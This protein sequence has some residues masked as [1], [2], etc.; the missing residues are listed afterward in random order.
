LDGVSGCAIVSPVLN[1]EDGSFSIFAWVKGGAPEQVVVSQ[2]SF[3][4]W[5]V[6][7]AEGNL[8]TELKS[9]NQ[10]AGPLHSETVITDGQ[11]HRIGLVWDDLHRIL[12]VPWMWQ[13][14][15]TR[16]LLLWSD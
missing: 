7:D 10:L 16:D 3:A 14:H 11:W 1:P 13:E 12:S 6:V 8:M 15:G 2:Q 4:G 5:L 9:S